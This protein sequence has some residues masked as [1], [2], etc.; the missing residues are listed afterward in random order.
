MGC[1]DLAVRR[2]LR[3]G[4]SPWLLRCGNREL[5]LPAGQLADAASFAIEA[6]A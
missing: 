3:D 2:G 1:G 5:V 6:A 4:G